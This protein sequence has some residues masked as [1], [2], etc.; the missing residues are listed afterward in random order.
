L[1]QQIDICD[2]VTSLSEAVDLVDTRVNHHHKRVAYIAYKISE[3][4]GLSARELQEIVIAGQ[5]HDIGALIINAPSNVAMGSHI[6][7]LA[8]RVEILI[9]NN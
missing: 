6:L 7:H 2:V 5:L 3:E 9:Q 4:L 8:D 1:F